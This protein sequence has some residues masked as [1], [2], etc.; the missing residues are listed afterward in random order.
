MLS[1]SKLVVILIRD[2]FHLNSVFLIIIYIL[3]PRIYQSP[4]VMCLT[5][6]SKTVVVV[7]I[8]IIIIINY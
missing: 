7:V 1:C 6:L 3:H 5:S 4:N 8:I 2:N